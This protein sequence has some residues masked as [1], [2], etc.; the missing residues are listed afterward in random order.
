MTAHTLVHD[1]EVHRPARRLFTLG[2][3]GFGLLAA[4]LV[5][6]LGMIAFVLFAF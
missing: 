4:T 1:E 2:W 6:L 3:A 5:A